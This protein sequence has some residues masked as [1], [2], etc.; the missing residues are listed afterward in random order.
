MSLTAPAWSRFAPTLAG[1]GG[2]LLLW[3]LAADL[4]ASIHVI[5]SPLA[6]AAQLVAD[7]ATYPLNIATTLREALFGY[8]WG[9]LTAILFAALFVEFAVVERIVLKLA[10]ASYCVPLVAIA[11]ILVVVLPGDGPKVALAALAVFFTTLV[12]AVL[13]LRSM[14]AVNV[15]LIRA[16]GGGPGESSAWCACPARCPASSRA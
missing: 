16:A 1:I 8:L 7:R 5:P 6:V 10:I 15:D 14:D 2:A 13:G 4:F 9:N 12:A 3:L 11:P